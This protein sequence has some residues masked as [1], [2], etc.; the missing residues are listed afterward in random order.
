[1]NSLFITPCCCPAVDNQCRG[2]QFTSQGVW[3]GAPVPWKLLNSPE[4]YD[5]SPGGL[6]DSVVDTFNLFATYAT[7][8]FS[9]LS[10][11]GVDNITTPARSYLYIAPGGPSK[12]QGRANTV[13][14]TVEC[15]FEWDYGDGL[16]EY[17]ASHTLTVNQNGVNGIVYEISYSG[18]CGDT[19]IYQ[20][21]AI[22]G[23]VTISGTLAA[24]YLAW[25]AAPSGA[26]RLDVNCPSGQGIADLFTRLSAAGVGGLASYGANYL[27]EVR[28]TG[29]LSGS[30]DPYAILWQYDITHGGPVNTGSYSLQ[31][32][33]VIDNVS[34]LVQPMMLINQFGVDPGSE[35][36]IWAA[37]DLSYA[38]SGTVQINHGYRAIRTEEFVALFS[39][40]DFIS[41]DPMIGGN[42][43]LPFRT[44]LLDDGVNVS[45]QY[46]FAGL[47]FADIAGQVHPEPVTAQRAWVYVS[48]EAFQVTTGQTAP[49]HQVAP[50]EAIYG[51]NIVPNDCQFNFLA[52]G[53]HRIEPAMMVYNYG[54]MTVT[55]RTIPAPENLEEGTGAL[56]CTNIY[57]DEE[58]E[59]LFDSSCGA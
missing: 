9:Y 44:I 19:W 27:P 12:F 33:N 30:E 21:N 46:Y 58:W 15:T 3:W 43:I 49:Y 59:A 16:Q 25:L 47:Y 2:V 41:G 48:S 8:Q 18:S 55:L 39:L 51:A 24:D 34:S 45:Q 36:E 22:T 10:A 38:A 35:A 52:Q 42:R 23:E 6:S 54:K 32:G 40:N 26:F 28:I 56:V 29:P 5:P 7:W 1:M 31:F 13:T 37:Y 53:G 57:T 11:F 17:T 14:E 50:P 20:F 4:A